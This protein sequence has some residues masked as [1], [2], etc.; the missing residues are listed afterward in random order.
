MARISEI[1]FFAGGLEAVGT[2]SWYNPNRIL[3][4][5]CD[6]PCHGRNYYDKQKENVEWDFYPDGDPYNRDLCK[7]LLDI[8][9]KNI[10]YF[11]VQLS[12]YTAK[13]FDEFQIIYSPIFPLN[14]RN[15]DDVIKS[16]AKT[17]TATIN[18]TIN[19]TMSV[20]KT[21]EQR[22]NYRL[23]NMEPDWNVM[24]TYPITITEYILP[25]TI[26]ELFHPLFVGTGQGTMQIATNPFAQGSLR[27][28]YYG[29][30]A[31]DGSNMIDVVY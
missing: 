13:M 5:L 15:P 8:K 16:V 9:R 21:T 27:Y 24:N 28:A 20:F 1:A 19:D 7:I 11:S 17:I 18:T 2:L 26:E 23:T 31:L 6:A 25:M 3:I 14:I 12:E 29:K 22:K 30:L 10:Q 4:H